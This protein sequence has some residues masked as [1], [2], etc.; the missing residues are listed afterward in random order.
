MRN[1]G[2][3]LK[4]AAFVIVAFFGTQE[5]RSISY[6][7]PIPHEIVQGSDAIVDAKVVK[8]T[9]PAGAEKHKHFVFSVVVFRVQGT[10]KGTPRK[11]DEIKM[12]FR[13]HG[14]APWS[15]PEEYKVGEKMM[16][17]LHR[18]G[19]RQR[20]I[21]KK[22]LKRYRE[23][24]EPIL[25]DDGWEKHT[26]TI[27][28]SSKR[29]LL[30]SLEHAI[31][32]LCEVWRAPTEFIDDNQF[33]G[34]AAYFLAERKKLTRDQA[35]RALRTLDPHPMQLAIRASAKANAQNTIP[36]LREIAVKGKRFSSIETRAKETK[37]Q[38]LISDSSP[39]EMAQKLPTDAATA[40]LAM[41]ISDD[42]RSKFLS[43]FAIHGP[44]FPKRIRRSGRL[45]QEVIDGLTRA[46][47]QKSTPE[48]LR[49]LVLTNPRVGYASLK[50]YATTAPEKEYGELIGLVKMYHTAWAKR[51]VMAYPGNGMEYF[52]HSDI[53][54]VFRY[55]RHEL[56]PDQRLQL[57]HGKHPGWDVW[58]REV[59][60]A[61]EVEIK[62]FEKDGPDFSRFDLEKYERI[63]F[64][65]TVDGRQVKLT[66]V[67][68]KRLI[69]IVE[70]AVTTNCRG[71]D[72]RAKAKWIMDLFE[73]SHDPTGFLWVA[74]DGTFGFSWLPDRA[75]GKSAA[76]RDHLR[77]IRG[78]PLDRIT[79]Q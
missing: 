67:E 17:I 18:F 42:R 78:K 53:C 62:I 25:V 44:F 63:H 34:A 1:L 37:R 56:D 23:V 73:G 5:A 9:T 6:A 33:C 59:V 79:R 10:L 61:A 38:N 8:V 64:L 29:F 74:E 72:P 58:G 76:L 31:R 70:R 7:Y 57:K 54:S 48:M 2:D 27:S 21:F 22:Q 12:L 77:S 43:E 51:W 41:D 14:E 4:C 32:K 45:R 30:G 24:E 49:R 13:S 69:Q 47:A 55:T 3:S 71:L 46:I 11:G 75:W 26:W 60:K 15:G 39:I 50:A 28:D 66:D 35:A 68:L 20:K 52:R 36:L 40:I 19:E 16:L 65:D